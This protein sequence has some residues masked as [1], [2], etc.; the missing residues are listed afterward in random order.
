MSRF[1]LN[2]PWLRK[3][4]PPSEFPREG[5]SVVSDD[6]QLTADYFGGGYAFREPQ[7]WFSEKVIT[8]PV[9]PRNMV[10][11]DMMPIDQTVRIIRAGVRLSAGGP[12][13]IN[14]CGALYAVS[15]DSNIF[16]PLTPSPGTVIIPVGSLA[17]EIF[18]FTIATPLL[19]PGSSF[20][21]FYFYSGDAAVN[22]TFSFLSCAAPRGVAI[23]A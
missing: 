13:G 1:T 6:V 9:A 3:V 22:Y 4:F 12:L 2:V 21:Y 23:I 17:G 10:P 20:L 16:V 14:F 7:Q 19:V 8:M 5:P 18:P 11:I 15:P